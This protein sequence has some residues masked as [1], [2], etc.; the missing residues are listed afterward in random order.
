MA[1][2]RPSTPTGRWGAASPGLPPRR[3]SSRPPIRSCTT[4]TC[5]SP[6]DQAPREASRSSARAPRATPRATTRSSCEPS[7]TRRRRP[8]SRPAPMASATRPST[9]RPWSLC[10]SSRRWRDTRASG[11]SASG[12][13]TSRPSCTTAWASWSQRSA[14]AWGG[15]PSTSPP[16]TSRTGAGPTAPMDMR[17]RVPSSTPSSARPSGAATSPA[18]SSSTPPSARGR[19]SAGSGASR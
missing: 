18:C 2:R 11:W 19:R 16:A 10:T 7:A 4:T 12:C 17:R 8:A 5:T 6:P 15:G 3:S 1:S 14:R 13:P 9:T